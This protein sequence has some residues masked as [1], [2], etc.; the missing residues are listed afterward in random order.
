MDSFP[1]D[2]IHVDNKVYEYASRFLPDGM[3]LAV[4]GNLFEFIYEYLLGY[5]GMFYLLSDDP[6]LVAA[7]FERWGQVMF[8]YYA[9]V[10]G[11]ETV[12]AIFH[13]DDMGY[14]TSTLI[15]PHH[16]RLYLFPWLKKIAAL[17]H[18]HGKT[19]WLHSCGNLYRHQ[20]MEDLIEN[21][22]IDAFHSFQDIIMPVD[23]FKQR[24]GHRVAVL[25]GVDMDSLA[26]L[27]ED[28]LRRYI[29]NIINR[30]ASGG[31]FALGSG[32]TIA[33]FIPLRNFQ[34]LLEESRRG[35]DLPA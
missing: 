10:I 14:K 19:F 17:A 20:V 13:C 23:E 26:T 12:G 27:S 5:E 33:N 7:A 4:C 11:L 25:G 30:C 1:W 8:D 29:R 22:K 2:L 9:S 35:V 28:N 34:I 3:K 6:K 24:Y 32:N 16:L 31:R 21:V 15:S 18:D